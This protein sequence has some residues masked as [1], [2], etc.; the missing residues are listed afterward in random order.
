LILRFAEKQDKEKEDKEL[1]G[2]VSSTSKPD[3]SDA[4]KEASPELKEKAAESPPKDESQVIEEQEIL[5]T[6]IEIKPDV[7]EMGIVDPNEPFSPSALIEETNIDDDEVI[8]L[9]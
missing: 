5:E 1:N 8:I 4:K 3:K 7:M 6:A 2:E 9:S